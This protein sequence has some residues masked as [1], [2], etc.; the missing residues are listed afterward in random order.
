M[1]A[2]CGLKNHTSLVKVS[3]VKFN[4]V[5]CLLRSRNPHS[6]CRQSLHIAASA[7]LFEARPNLGPAGDKPVLDVVIV[8]GGI[9]GLATA[10]A[11]ASEHK[12]K[13]LD[14]VRVLGASELFEQRTD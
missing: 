7:A 9:S 8:G 11:L 5:W 6:R 1:F 10:Q 13:S 4:F 12:V 14:V 3:S 2:N